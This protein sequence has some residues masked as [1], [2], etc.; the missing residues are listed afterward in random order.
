MIYTLEP[1]YV[2]PSRKLFADTVVR[3]M[4]DEVA[5]EVKNCLS[6]AQRVAL[7]CD[8]WTSRATESYVTLTA[9]H[10]TDDW[11]LSSH[12]LQPRAF[13]ESHTGANLAELLRGVAIEWNL[14]DKDP[15]L[16]TDNAS[17]KVIAAQLTGFLHIKCYAHTL[18]LASLRTLKLPAVVKLLRRVRCITGYFHRS[19]AGL[20]VL[21][22]K[23]KLVDTAHKLITD[24][25]TR[26]L[27]MTWLKVFWS[28]K[29]Q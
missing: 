16:V 2:I 7:S 14:T 6:K 10:I 25:S 3:K 28:N 15:A 23:Q 17:N 24:F 22:E 29:L 21:Q 13:H 27:P 5:S 8:A 1:R 12:V 26:I 20:H 11:H 9:H 4:Y 18:N 19:A